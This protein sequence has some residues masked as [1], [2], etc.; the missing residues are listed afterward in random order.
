MGELVST[1]SGAFGLPAIFSLALSLEIIHTRARRFEDNMTTTLYLIRGLPGSGKSTVAYEMMVS[2]TTADAFFI[3]R[4]GVYRFDSSKLKAA[5]AWCLQETTRHIS[6]G[7]TTVVHNTFTQRW[8][9]EPYIQLAERAGA[10][11]VVV[12][13]FDGG[14]TDEELAERNSHGV[15]VEAIARMRERFE[16]DWRK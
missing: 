16:H 6:E 8:E 1:R 3:D 4:D 7:R 12:S 11:L 15:P 9:M 10:R 2:D 13:V 5:H 14:L